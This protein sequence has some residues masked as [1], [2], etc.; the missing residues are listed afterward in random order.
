MKR[1]ELEPGTFFL[2][3]CNRQN[4]YWIAVPG[5][6]KPE[7]VLFSGPNPQSGD[8]DL[9]VEVLSAEDARRRGLAYAA[10]HAPK[11]QVI[12]AEDEESGA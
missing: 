7:G 1:R 9:E 10:K 11:P 12:D 4:T 2:Y 8:W 5:V 3:V 6:E